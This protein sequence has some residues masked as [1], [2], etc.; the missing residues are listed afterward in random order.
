[1][2][3]ECLQPTCC[4][5]VWT[6]ALFL[7]H[8]K[9]IKVTWSNSLTWTCRLHVKL[10]VWRFKD[11]TLVKDHFLSLSGNCL[12]IVSLAWNPWHSAWQ[13]NL[14]QSP[15]NTSFPWKT[16]RLAVYSVP[17]CLSLT[18]DHCSAAGPESRL[19]GVLSCCCIGSGCTSIE[20]IMASCY[21]QYPVFACH[22]I[23]CHFG[24]SA[25]TT[26]TQNHQIYNFILSVHF[27][28]SFICPTMWLQLSPHTW[29]Y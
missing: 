17:L 10:C 14:F 6:A 8:T 4:V 12:S 16:P 23:Y 3:Q 7:N 19:S 13:V 21:I 26:P 22:V 25:L 2:W 24:D 11:P 5:Y 15:L 28:S 1:M 27:I 18:A 9:G 29:Q 20:P